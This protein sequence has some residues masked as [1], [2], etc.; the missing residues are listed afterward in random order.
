MNLFCREA[1]H[2]LGTEPVPRLE[3]RQLPAGGL[4]PLVLLSF[5]QP[6]VCDS[7]SLSPSS[8]PRA[9]W[10]PSG[11]PSYSGP[12]FAGLSEHF[13]FVF[14]VM[15]WV[16]LELVVLKSHHLQYLWGL[17]YY[18]VNF[19]KCSF[20]RQSN[21]CFQEKFNT[22]GSNLFILSIFLWGLLEKWYSLKR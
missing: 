4:S 13:V 1:S 8:L 22:K 17:P 11:I 7:I 2:F 15:S 12:P 10:N 6:G 14:L 19:F 5:L 20:V 16:L 18:I 3:S 9:S 21:G